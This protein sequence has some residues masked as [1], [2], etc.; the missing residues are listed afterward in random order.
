MIFVTCTLT[1]YSLAFPDTYTT[2]LYI[3]DMAMNF[4]FAIDLVV[5][6]IS[7]Y[8]DSEM[9]LIDDFKVR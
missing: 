8:Y 4:V 9:Q 3:F 2:N 6:F 1:P 7:A 5:N